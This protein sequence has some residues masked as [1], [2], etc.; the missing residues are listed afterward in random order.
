MLTQS[1]WWHERTVEPVPGGTRLTDQLSWQ[2]RTA[3]F[4]AMYA[5]AIPVIFRHRH[6][7]L[8]R[9]LGALTTA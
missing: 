9:L 1:Q 3:L 2:G 5:L 7:R 8:R 4:G 6:S